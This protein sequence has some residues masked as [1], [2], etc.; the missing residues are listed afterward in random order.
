MLQTGDLI[1]FRGDRKYPM[2]RL[3]MDFTGSKYTHVGMIIQNPSW[4]TEKGLFCLQS[5]SH[6]QTAAEQQDRHSGV[7]LTPLSEMGQFD[8]R[9]LTTV[10]DKAF[11]NRLEKVH[12]M[13][14]NL[15]YDYSV[16]DWIRSGLY[17]IGLHWFST[18]RHTNNF[19]CS[20]LCAFVYN[21]LGL[22]DDID[23]SNQTPGDLAT[24]DSVLLPSFLSVIRESK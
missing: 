15:P 3:I 6:K 12:A 9:H 13:V 16:M 17:A 23:W 4:M 22:F 24:T 20:A 1:F 5:N 10:R 11:Y 21:E 8:V 2:D 14:H 7:V 19:W 18:P